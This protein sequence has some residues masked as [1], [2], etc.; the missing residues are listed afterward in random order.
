MGR[1]LRRDL[2]AWLTGLPASTTL[3]ACLFLPQVEDCHHHLHNPAETGTAPILIVLALLGLLPLVWRWPPLRKPLAAAVGLALIVALCAT[4]VGIPVAVLFVL[5]RPW[6]SEARPEELEAQVA[7][8]AGSVTLLFIFVFPL[9]GLLMSWRL[10][11]SLTWA[12][13]WVQLV[14]MLMWSSAAGTRAFAPVP[15]AG[16]TWS[17]HTAAP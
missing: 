8:A 5:L 14:A 17:R 7:I 10:G 12:A 2:A 6:R 11:G 4:K 3:V 13:A 16:N 15:I 1:L 9:V